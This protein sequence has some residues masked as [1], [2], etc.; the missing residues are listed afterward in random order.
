MGCLVPAL[1]GHSSL[2]ECNETCSRN[3]HCPMWV[4]SKSH[5]CLQAQPCKEASPT[6]WLGVDGTGHLI[7]HGTITVERKVT[8][9]LPVADLIDVGPLT[10]WG[11]SEDEG[12][13][14]RLC[15]ADSR[16]DYWHYGN[17]SCWV[18]RKL[19]DESHANTG[20]SNP[21]AGQAVVGEAIT[22]RCP[23]SA[24]PLWLY[25]GIS[26]AALGL[27]M[28]AFASFRGRGTT[29]EQLIKD[30]EVVARELSLSASSS[31]LSPSET[32]PT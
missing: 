1:G 19:Q 28:C 17:G 15:Y 32:P 25:I 21:L 24:H 6:S 10:G 20:E 3:V 29:R 4:Y 23:H 27:C 12:R 11:P 14:K 30:F 18:Q 7:Q 31:S 8:T 16:C 5:G 22:R 26:A 13:C 2:A 9:G